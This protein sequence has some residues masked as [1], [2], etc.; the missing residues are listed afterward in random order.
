MAIMFC[1]KAGR[2]GK[3]PQT[4]SE[5]VAFME[6]YEIHTATELGEKFGV[7]PATIRSWA[8]RIRKEVKASVGN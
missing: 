3:F 6:L 5:K 1:K 4:E 8:S 7:Q 2:P